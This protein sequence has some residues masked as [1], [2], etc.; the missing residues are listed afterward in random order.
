MY[1]PNANESPLNPLPPVVWLMA[2]AI[3]VPELLLQ[4]GEAGFVGGPEA[5]GWRLDLARRYGF[6]DPVFDWMRQTGNY[7]L[8]HLQRFVS[9]SPN[10]SIRWRCLRYF[11]AARLSGPCCIPS[12]W[13]RR[14]C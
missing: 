9:S 1:D 8:E 2:L 13:T 10:C 4:A 3:A 14:P 11:W 12:F 5:I 7:P 6:L